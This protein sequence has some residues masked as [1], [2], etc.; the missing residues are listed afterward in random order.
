MSFVLHHCIAMVSYS[1]KNSNHQLD[2][3]IKTKRET[4][5]GRKKTLEDS[6]ENQATQSHKGERIKT[7]TLKFKLEVMMYGEL[8]GNCSAGR[9]FNVDVRRIL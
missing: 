7:Y 6:F 4:F 9:K 1:K 5:L 8:K 2:I 3:I